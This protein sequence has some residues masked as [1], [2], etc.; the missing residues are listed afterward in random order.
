MSTRSSQVLDYS[1]GGSG[2]STGSFVLDW[3][4]NKDQDGN[5]K[6]QFYPEDIVY[7]L[8]QPAPGEEYS[9]ISSSL[10]SGN[11]SK[12]GNVTR[13]VKEDFNFTGE[14]N[15]HSIQYIPASN[16]VTATFLS[17]TP[18][19]SVSSS[20]G[21]IVASG[22]LPAIGYFSYKAQFLSFAFRAGSEVRGWLEQEQAK[23]STG[24]TV[25]P[26]RVLVVATDTGV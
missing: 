18:T 22:A 4:K 11:F 24:E 10:L 14:K 8:F 7:L 1:G 13:T 3:E 9:G 15:T 20:T 21:E 17:K 16:V 23:L 19:L 5:E 12:L 25:E 6:T 26:Y 2:K